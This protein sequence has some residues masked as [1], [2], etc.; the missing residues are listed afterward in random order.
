M[1]RRLFPVTVGLV[2]LALA[3]AG[4]S[5]ALEPTDP[6]F[7]QQWGLRNTGQEV[8]YRSGTPGA[9]VD[10]V[11]A[12]DLSTGA[13]VV[14]GV[15][16]TGVRY[17]DTDLAANM[18]ENNPGLT[19]DGKTC[20]P[21]S[22]G[23]DFVQGDCDPYD[24]HGHGTGV[25][26]PA[27]ADGNNGIGGL[28]LAH[29]GRVMALR[30]DDAPV[31]VGWASANAM[32]R[33][34]DWAIAARD[35]GVNVRVLSI[36]YGGTF[37]SGG[38]RSAIQRAGD[39]GILVVAA[40]GNDN[41]SNDEQ[42]TYPCA[43][44]PDNLICVGGSDQDDRL[45]GNWGP[46][47]VDLVAPASNIHACGSG[48]SC[49]APFVAAAAALIWS[50]EPDL[51]VAEVRGKILTNVDPLPDPA[52]R[53][54]IGTG[55][56]LNAYEAL[57]GPS[58]LSSTP[59]TTAPPSGGGGSG[60]GSEGASGT[61]AG[62]G[63]S[64]TEGGSTGTGANGGSEARPGQSGAG[65]GGGTAVRG[66]ETAKGSSPGNS[67]KG[68][69]SPGPG[70]D[71]VSGAD[72]GIDGLPVASPPRGNVRVTLDDGADGSG[73]FPLAV[74]TAATALAAGAFAWWRRRPSVPLGTAG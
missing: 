23:Y 8:E 21:G 9:D 54:K 59:T 29:G 65:G 36:S 61:P 16:D 64:G 40:S 33:G 41:R 31:L 55:G 12:W 52:D 24:G 27:A 73:G 26:M 32:A 46:T 39:H 68:G 28:G 51:S 14:I 49:A 37:Y 38:L 56:R 60:G 42:P 62:G 17:D 15:I 34:I 6:D 20:P 58:G 30:V 66:D 72:D 50:R 1:T 10:A 7:G 22:H 53:A 19:I 69:T 13:G 18:W 70:I 5:V 63:S 25:S 47:S 43:Y 71:A 4:P 35:Q 3:A 2:L 74:G 67:A 57:R 45:G 44:D 11:P 48:T